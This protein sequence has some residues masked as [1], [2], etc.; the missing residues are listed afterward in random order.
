LKPAQ[1]VEEDAVKFVGAR[2]LVT[3]V[4][5]TKAGHDTEFLARHLEDKRL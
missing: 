2:A 1:I 5:R 4:A 3:W